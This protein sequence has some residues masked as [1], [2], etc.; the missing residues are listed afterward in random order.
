MNIPVLK[1]KLSTACHGR[2]FTLVE[3]LIV[4]TILSILAI[5]AMPSFQSVTKKLQ[6]TEAQALMLEIQSHL[7]R[8]YFVNHHYPKGLSALSVYT[9][10]RITSGKAKYEIRL[11]AAASTCPQQNCYRLVAEHVNRQA[12]DTLVLHSNGQREGVW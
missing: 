3:L 1:T 6:R 9:D 5:M 11:D 10:D 12:S 7:E 2:G 8:Y 4:M